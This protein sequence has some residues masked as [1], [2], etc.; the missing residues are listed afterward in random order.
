MRGGALPLI[1]AAAAD[2]SAR[3]TPSG[4][5][6]RSRSEPSP[7]PSSHLT[8]ITALSFAAPETVRPGEPVAAQPEASS[9]DEFRLVHPP[10][11]WRVRIRLRVRSLP[12]LLRRRHDA[13]WRQSPGGRVSRQRR[14]GRTAARSRTVTGRGAGTGVRAVAPRSSATGSSHRDPPCVS[15]DLALLYGAPPAGRPVG[16]PADVSFLAGWRC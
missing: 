11:G 4:P 2:A 1:W 13:R 9:A 14:A 10:L 6:T 7:P 12:D 8:L 5:A 15:P 3:S 16:L